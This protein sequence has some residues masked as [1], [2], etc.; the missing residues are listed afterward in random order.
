M[1]S[2]SLLPQKCQ[3]WRNHG[4]SHDMLQIDSL[5]YTD[6]PPSEATTL[7]W[8]SK[9]TV[10]HEKRPNSWAGFPFTTLSKWI[11]WPRIK[12]CPHTRANSYLQM[13]TSDW[14]GMVAHLEGQS[15]C[16]S[17]IKGCLFPLPTSDSPSVKLAIS[18]WEAKKT[19]WRKTQ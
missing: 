9:G 19:I 18:L 6:D 14:Q 4:D 12:G 15:C 7:S 16:F 17:P 10:S 3:A 13:I 8:F 1:V 5:Y 2:T 11:N